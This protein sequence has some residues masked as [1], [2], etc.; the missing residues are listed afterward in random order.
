MQ[1]QKPEI[2]FP[3]DFGLETAIQMCKIHLNAPSENSRKIAMGWTYVL[4]V[5]STLSR[6]PEEEEEIISDCYEQGKKKL[7]S[8][9]LGI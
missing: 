7:T 2:T 5:D 1:K 9:R 6:T 8:V 4:G 3:S